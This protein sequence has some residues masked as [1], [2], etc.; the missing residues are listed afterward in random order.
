MVLCSLPDPYSISDSDCKPNGHIELRVRFHIV[1]SQIQITCT[2]PAAPYRN[3]T[4]IGIR[5]S[6][7]EFIYLFFKKSKIALKNLECSYPS[8]EMCHAW[9]LLILWTASV[10]CSGVFT[11]RQRDRQ[12]DQWRIGCKELGKCSH[13]RERR[14]HR[15][16]SLVLLH[17]YIYVS[18]SV[19][20]SVPDH[21]WGSS[22]WLWQRHE[23]A[24]DW[25]SGDWRYEMRGRRWGTRHWIT[26][27]I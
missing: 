3:G 4:G 8:R 25:D 13:Y 5:I 17:W 15:F 21:E 12:R 22:W 6:R 9:K 16:S 2:I 14:P 23:F 24:G 20:S 19:S 10:V 7:F 11:V 1:W 18:V 26:N 27:L